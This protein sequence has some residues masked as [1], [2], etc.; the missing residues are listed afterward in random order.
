MNPSNC[1][2]ETTLRALDQVRGWEA[3]QQP[4]R[5]WSDWD[6]SHAVLESAA[7]CQSIGLRT[8]APEISGV[9]A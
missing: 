4:A 6:I 8:A 7:S 3:S 1:I 2:R 5:A 9:S